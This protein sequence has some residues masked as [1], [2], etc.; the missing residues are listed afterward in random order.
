M[1]IDYLSIAA[2]IFC[3]AFFVKGARLDEQSPRVWGGLSVAVWLVSTQVPPGGVLGGLL[4]QLLLF[5]ALTLVN[6][7]RERVTQTRREGR[8]A[9]SKDRSRTSSARRVHGS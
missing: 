3:T 7:R 9:A 4:G 1:T 2:C 8:D 6:A 5:V